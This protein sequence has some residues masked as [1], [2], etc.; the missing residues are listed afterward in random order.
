MH[1]IIRHP[2]KWEEVKRAISIGES[3]LRMAK[4]NKRGIPLS[5]LK[6]RLH[7]RIPWSEMEE[8]IPE[9][10]TV[11]NAIILQDS[12][13]KRGRTAQLFVVPEDWRQKGVKQE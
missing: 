8:K 7:P 4:I 13:V 9:I 2:D 12:E 1:D 11:I 6:A 3:I 5:V 10:A